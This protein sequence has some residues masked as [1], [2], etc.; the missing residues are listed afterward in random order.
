MTHDPASEE[1]A[2]PSRQI[3]PAAAIRRGWRRGIG[4]LDRLTDHGQMSARRRQRSELRWGAAG[5]VVSLVAGVIAVGI[6]WYSPGHYRVLAEFS[7]AG[8]MQVG[9]SVRVAGVP[10]GTVKNIE[11]RSDHVEVVMAVR[12]GTPLGDLTRAD[13]KMLTIVGGS[14]VDLTS[15]GDEELGEAPIPVERTSVP[16]SLMKTFQTIQPKLEKVDVAPL[17]HTL[18]QFDEALDTN[19]GA[20]RKNIDVVYSMLTNLQQRQDQF[21]SMLKLAADYAEQINS[22]GD[23]ITQM[24]RNLSAFI[25][26]FA[27]FGP[28]LNV[29]LGRTALLLERLRSVATVYTDD[30]EPLVEQIDAIGRDFG[31]ALTRYTP[32]IEQGRDL[33]QRLEGMVGE[34][35]SIVVDHSNVVLSSDYCIPMAGVTC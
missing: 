2:K 20:L 26:E 4:L 34:D 29:V 31:P 6:Y 28:R 35:G 9:N 8:Q 7:E 16:Y 18:A 23:V 27:V 25:S 33:I 1:A 11:L 10:V 22:N 21:G 30:I 19:P 3:G 5:V 17:R 14:F 12:W 32:L 15:D 24:A 13:V